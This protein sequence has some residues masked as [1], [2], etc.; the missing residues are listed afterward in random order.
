[1][2]DQYIQIPP[3]GSGKK[4]RT[5]ENVVSATTVHHHA[6]TIVGTDGTVVSATPATFTVAWSAATN[7]TMGSTW[8]SDE[9]NISSYE[10]FSIGASWTATGS[11]VGIIKLQEQVGGNWYDR[12]DS[13]AV[14]N[15][16]STIGWDCWRI[17]APY[18]RV[19][20]AKTSGGTGAVCTGSGF[21][22]R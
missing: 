8:V 22:K 10:D 5:F 12:D 11:P 15:G 1:M 6:F 17:S 19:A 20:Y 2:S 21:L 14:V 13:T 4:V 9:I 16:A 18:I 7:V 3:D